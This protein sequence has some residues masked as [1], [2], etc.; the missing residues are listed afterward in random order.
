VLVDVADG[1]VVYRTETIRKLVALSGEEVMFVDELIALARES[2]INDVNL[3]TVQYAGSDDH[4]RRRFRRYIACFLHSMACVCATFL[5]RHPER[6][7]AYPVP[8]STKQP[9]PAGVNAAESE[10]DKMRLEPTFDPFN[11]RF[12]SAWITGTHNGFVWSYR[13]KRVVRSR[14][15]AHDDQESSTAESPDNLFMGPPQPERPIDSVSTQD[16]TGAHGADR[17]SNKNKRD[18]RAHRTTEAVVAPADG[19][20]E[21]NVM[22]RLGGALYDSITSIDTS[23]AMN[24]V[25]SFGTWA[26]DTMSGFFAP[27]A[28]DEEGKASGKTQGE[29]NGNDRADAGRNMVSVS[30]QPL[31]SSSHGKSKNSIESRERE[32]LQIPQNCDITSM[33]T[34]KVP[35]PHASNDIAASGIRLAPSARRND[36]R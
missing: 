27:F 3:G 6:R 15:G 4:L 26:F 12:A 17:P 14:A 7:R 32:H 21:L 29:W 22:D 35:P 13:S 23:A 18:N 24:E 9:A 25:S 33:E 31:K 20:N 10:F 11:A 34:P 19:S 5:E 1:R 28:G 2:S 16:K 8:S 36:H 30:T